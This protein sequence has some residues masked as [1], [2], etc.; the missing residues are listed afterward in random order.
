MTQEYLNTLDNFFVLALRE[1][2]T[3]TL[4][5]TYVMGYMSALFDSNVVVG[6]E[7]IEIE[8]ILLN[9]YSEAIHT[10]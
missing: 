8:R 6:Y 4:F 5:S 9:A 7:S 3:Y 1:E 10:K 2:L